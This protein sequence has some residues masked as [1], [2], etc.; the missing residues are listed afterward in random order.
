MKHG[1]VHHGIWDSTAYGSV[2]AGER[3]DQQ[4]QSTPQPVGPSEIGAWVK[5]C[6]PSESGDPAI[7]MSAM[8]GKSAATYGKTRGALLTKMFH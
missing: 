5:N 2:I 6:H 8:L 4:I 3:H 7:N 1:L